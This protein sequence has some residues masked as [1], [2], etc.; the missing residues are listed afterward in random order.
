MNLRRNN[1]KVNNDITFEKDKKKKNKVRTPCTDLPNEPYMNI[2][3][4]KP[5]RDKNNT[6]GIGTVVKVVCAKGYGLNIPENK[7]A[8]CIRGKW[9]PATPICS[10]RK[11]C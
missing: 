10:T 8:K 5:G 1:K 4:V 2:E 7:T 6:Y 9:R 3:I 11:F